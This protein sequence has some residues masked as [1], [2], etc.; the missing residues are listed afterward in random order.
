MSLTLKAGARV[1]GAAC[2]TEA[3]VV[4]APAEPVD[5]RIGGHPALLAAADRTPG[6]EVLTAAESKPAMGKRYVDADGSLEVLCTKAGA[7]A[8]AV[9]DAV[10]VQ[11]DAKALPASD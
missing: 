9:G 10:L 8:I 5:L 7:G 4:K 6:L 11:K 3:V 2:T 1:F